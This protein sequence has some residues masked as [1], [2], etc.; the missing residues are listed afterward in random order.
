MMPRQ[1][2]T[3]RFL[4]ASTKLQR[5]L[6]AL[7]MFL[8]C[9]IS[10]RSFAHRSRL[11]NARHSR[12][13]RCSSALPLSSLSSSRYPPRSRG[14]QRSGSGG[15]SCSFRFCSLAAHYALRFSPLGG[16][17]RFATR[18]ERTRRRLR[19]RRLR[20]DQT[21][22]RR[23]RDD[24]WC[25]RVERSEWC[26]VSFLSFFFCD[27]RLAC[28]SLR[29]R[30]SYAAF[31]G[32]YGRGPLVQLFRAE[33]G[34][35]QEDV[36]ESWMLTLSLLLCMIR[37]PPARHV[38]T[39]LDW[40]VGSVALHCFPAFSRPLFAALSLLG[41]STLFPSPRSDA[42][43]LLGTSLHASPRLPRLAAC[44]TRCSALRTSHRSGSMAE[45]LP[46]LHLVGLPSTSLQNSHALLHHT[47][48]NGSFDTFSAM[49][50]HL[51]ATVGILKKGS[52][53]T[54]EVDRVMG[55]ALT[56]VCPRGCEEIG[57]LNRLI[58]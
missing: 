30:C 24:V 8:R 33:S 31:S 56:E 52:R 45:R 12:H 23:P 44:L 13:S 46:I 53:W 11:A 17:L 57:A 10:T 4:D 19:R 18:S 47:L 41:I 54:E 58:V 48:G 2:W 34:A 16:S 42:L 3:P 15:H 20:P 7:R 51:V 6:F 25:G 26:C 21:W 35:Q 37:F 32:S 40:L 29:L 22:P 14:S 39:F 28:G 43:P 9:F 5:A 55:V 50:S 38:S 27:S 49:S 1:I 36:S